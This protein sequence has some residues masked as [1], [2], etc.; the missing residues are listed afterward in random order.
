ME[1]RK[2]I[3]LLDDTTNEPSEF[4]TRN[5]F[6]INDE[7]QGT[8]NVSNQIKFKTSLIRSHLCDHS[9]AYIHVKGTITVPN[10]GTAAAPNNRN[11]SVIFEIVFHLIYCIV[12]DAHDIDVVMSMYNLIEYSEAYLKTSGSYWLYNRGEPALNDINIIDFPNENNNSISFKFT[13]QITGQ[14]RN[15]NTNGVEIMVPLKYLAIFGEH[16]ICH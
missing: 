14:P 6:E 8:N 4:R 5:W 3:N 11:K 9:N 1:H 2:I 16:L 7:S 10:T 15:N 13:H 12:D